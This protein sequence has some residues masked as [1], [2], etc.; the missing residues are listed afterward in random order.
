VPHG[1]DR[2]IEV[3]GHDPPP[4]VEV[5]V[6][7]AA[8]P[9]TD[10]NIVDDNIKPPKNSTV[11]STHRASS[12]RLARLPTVTRPSLPISSTLCRVEAARSGDIS[13]MATLRAP[14]GAEQLPYP[15]WFF[16]QVVRW[17]A[18]RLGRTNRG[19]G[20]A[21]TRCGPHSPKQTSTPVERAGLGSV[22]RAR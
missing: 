13:A 7:G 19:R 14:G 1:Q 9:A 15:P 11:S 8:A 22:F 17:R 18:S 21:E 2:G 6:N 16:L 4:G 20:E 3:D 5:N 12:S 10:G